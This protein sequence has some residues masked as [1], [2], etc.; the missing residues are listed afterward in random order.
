MNSKE[1]FKSALQLK[2]ELAV[3]C[4]EHCEDVGFNKVSMKELGD[5]L[6]LT[7]STL[8]QCH[9]LRNEEKGDE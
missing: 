4:I 3:I 6:D 9:H 7:I 5:T 2:N 1:Q 8:I